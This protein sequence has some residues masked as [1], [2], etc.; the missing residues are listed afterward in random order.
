LFDLGKGFY[1]GLAAYGKLSFPT[2]QPYFN[3]E[4]LGYDEKFVRGYE[5]FVVDGQHYLLGR[6]EAKY[7][8]VDFD[9]ELGNL[10]PIDQFNTIPIQAYIKLFFDAGYVQDDSFNP[11]NNFLTNRALYGGGIGLDVVTFYDNVMRIETALNDRG[12]LGLYFHM[13]RAL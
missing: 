9:V 11:F 2:D 1:A 6:S 5:L 3:T 4:G 10:I 13:Q 8:L 12:D 7:K